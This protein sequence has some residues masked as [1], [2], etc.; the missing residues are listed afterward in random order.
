MPRY[1]D[2]SC[3]LLAG[4]PPANVCQSTTKFFKVSGEQLAPRE[5]SRG[6]HTLLMMRAEPW[7]GLSRAD[8]AQ[9]HPPKDP[10]LSP[11]AIHHHNRYEC[12]SWMFVGRP[13]CFPE[14]PVYY[15]GRSVRFPAATAWHLCI[16]HDNTEASDERLTQVAEHIGLTLRP[17]LSCI[18]QTAH[19]V[20]AAHMSCRGD[21]G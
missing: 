8:R 21:Q 16:Q 10:H 11:L 7:N 4:L 3:Q 13:G 20:T 9:L 18:G 1:E 14:P 17:L 6:C 15:E 5:H 2:I 19:N 12:N